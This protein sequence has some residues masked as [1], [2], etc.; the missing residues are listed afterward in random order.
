MGTKKKKTDP[1]KE[2][3]KSTKNK[4]E[5]I[6]YSPTTTPLTWSS[7]LYVQEL[8]KARAR[9]EILEANELERDYK[10]SEI[11]LANQCL[12][13]GNRILEEQVTM[14][15][16]AVEEGK[17]EWENMK[18]AWQSKNDIMTT[19]K[20]VIIYKTTQVDTQMGHQKS[21]PKRRQKITTIHTSQNKSKLG[22][23]TLIVTR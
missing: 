17:R 9:L 7:D 3:M 14:L 16:D 8:M 19:N 10:L 4:E 6:M 23:R 5:S 11:T 21:F 12:M 2:K 15:Q 13:E 22:L 20:D 1:E 18:V